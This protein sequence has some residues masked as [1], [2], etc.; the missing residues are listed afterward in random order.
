VTRLFIHA[1]LIKARS[2]RL[3]KHGAGLRGTT[4]FVSEGDLMFTFLDNESAPDRGNDERMT[5]VSVSGFRVQNRS[6]PRTSNIE[7]RTLNANDF[8]M[9]DV[10]NS[11]DSNRRFNGRN[12]RGTIVWSVLPSSRLMSSWGK[13][14]AAKSCDPRRADA[15]RT[16]E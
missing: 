8:A 15:G 9:S 13:M 2:N 4:L 1:E 16:R 14:L 12:S 10:E 7:H 6:E 11:S 3:R 5:K